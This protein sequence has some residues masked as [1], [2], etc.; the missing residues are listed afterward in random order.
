MRQ[1]KPKRPFWH[2]VQTICRT[3]SPN[4]GTVDSATGIITFKDGVPKHPTL[5]KFSH[6]PAT[7]F[8]EM[9]RGWR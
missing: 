6:A 4:R 3:G 9:Q 1:P 7:D 5:S 8:V 2:I